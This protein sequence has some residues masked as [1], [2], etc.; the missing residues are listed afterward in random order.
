[1]RRRNRLA[2]LLCAA[3]LPALAGCAGGL[4]RAREMGDM[5]LMRTLGVDAGEQ[6][7]EYLVTASSSRRARGVQGEEEPPLVLSAR[8]SSVAGACLA[9]ESMGESS[10]FYG[11][12][13][14]LLLGE[15]LAERDALETLFYFAR[16]RELGMGAQVWLVRGDTAQ[17]VIQARKDTGVDNRLAILQSG[18]EQGEAEVSRTVGETLT[19]LLED[20]SA[21]LPALELEGGELREVGYGVL[22]GGTLAGFLTGVQA[23]GLELAQGQG[24]P[25]LVEL[26]GDAVRVERAELT[27]LPEFEGEA[28]TG[29]SLD[30]RLTARVVQSGG[31][32]DRDRLRERLEAL[33]C[34]RLRSAVE[35][36]QSWDADCLGLGRMA[37]S[38]RPER[39]GELRAQWA[40]RFPHLKLTV[41]CAASLSGAE[42]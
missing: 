14:Q 32:T 30:L 39:W 10:V 24:G 37:G 27:C 17:A 36:L 25:E 23:R 3:L 31:E 6:A 33:A 38:S 19:A 20:G 28:L 21:Y 41:R 16:D 8:R 34:A 2:A 15:E 9:M 7:G 26:E 1:M 42:R 12:V 4:P 5:A 35:Q 11:H 40:E 18:G 29:L 13:D 22:K